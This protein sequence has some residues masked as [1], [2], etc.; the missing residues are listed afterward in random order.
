MRGE[1]GGSERGETTGSAGRREGRRR[2]EQATC[3]DEVGLTE[4]CRDCRIELRDTES[5]ERQAYERFMADACMGSVRG[6]LDS[7][8]CRL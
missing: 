6:I 1:G 5:D 3:A 8:F 2:E 4:V 7:L